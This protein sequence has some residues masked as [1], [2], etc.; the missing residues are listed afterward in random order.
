MDRYPAMHVVSSVLRYI[1][2][3]V[4]VIG[5][6]GFVLYLLGGPVSQSSALI[7]IAGA[8]GSVVLGILLYALGDFFRCILDI[9]EHT[10]SVEANT[11]V[12]ELKA[13]SN[14]GNGASGGTVRATRK[15]KVPEQV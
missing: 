10:R 13:K 15:I 2:I 9:E 7:F 8:V 4:A 12:N 6:G 11:K 14:G 1:A 3:L 5:L